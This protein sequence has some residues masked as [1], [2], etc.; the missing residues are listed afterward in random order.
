MKR[1]SPAK[2]HHFWILLGLVPLLTLIAVVVVNAK[3]GGEIDARQAK[4]KKANEDIA[5][6]K[7]PKPDKLLTALDSVAGVVDKKQ[8][9]LHKENWDRQKALFTWPGS[10]RPGTSAVFAAIEQKGLKFGE[11]SPT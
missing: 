7:N 4:I 8:T 10:T 5:A 2:K 1:E 3:V 11:A 6:K 9:S